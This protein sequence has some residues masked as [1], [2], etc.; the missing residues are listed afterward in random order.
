VAR[1]LG[2]VDY[3]RER[4]WPAQCHPQGAEDFVCE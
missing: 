4:G 3:W 1:G 2:L